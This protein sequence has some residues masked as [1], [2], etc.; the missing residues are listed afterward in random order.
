MKC[1]KTMKAQLGNKVSDLF[2]LLI[3]AWDGKAEILGAGPAGK[4][5]NYIFIKKT[6]WWWG[7]I[8][9]IL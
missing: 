9:F 1:D 2:L 5:F 7:R 6:V 8:W 3:V 4:I